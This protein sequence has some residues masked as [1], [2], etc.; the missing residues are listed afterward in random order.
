MFSVQMCPNTQ[1]EAGSEVYIMDLTQKKLVPLKPLVNLIDLIILHIKSSWLSYIYTYNCIHIYML[2]PMIYPILHPNLVL[3]AYPHVSGLK[4]PFEA[5]TPEEV[6]GD[7]YFISSG[8]PM[9]ALI[10]LSQQVLV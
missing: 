7:A 2:Y 5:T 1:F 10:W 9:E 8:C 4:H 3:V 6:I